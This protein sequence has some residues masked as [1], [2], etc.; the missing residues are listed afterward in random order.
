MAGI[1]LDGAGVQKMKT[2]EE[3]LATMQQI[4]GIVERMALDVKNNRGLGLGPGQIKRIATNL[5]G[6]LKG[7]F[8][9][10]ADQVAAM[11]I[12]MGRGGGEQGK[13]RVCREAVGQIRTA[14]EINASKVK[15]DHAVEIEISPD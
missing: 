1:K 9:L 13:I 6:Q 14:L 2:L 7:Q 4:H 15:K 12:G 10:I 5:Q 8:G 11:I 3:A